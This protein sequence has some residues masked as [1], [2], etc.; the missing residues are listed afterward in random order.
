MRAWEQREFEIQHLFF[1]NDKSTY[2][3]ATFPDWLKHKEIA[4]FVSR[5]IR[6]LEI[7]DSTETDFHKITRI[8]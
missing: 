3:P 6:T 5:C 8:K 2:T 7:N 1:E 4:W